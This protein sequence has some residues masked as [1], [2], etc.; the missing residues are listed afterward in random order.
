[1]TKRPG[2]VTAGVLGALL[3]AC[4][5]SGSTGLVSPEGAL[6]R[7]VRRD[8]TCVTSDQMVTYCA[9]GSPDAVSPGG[10]TA[11]GPFDD[12][13]SPAPTAT[14]HAS[15]Q[16]PT[17]GSA[18]SATF[19]ASPTPVPSGAPSASPTP[20]QSNGGP[21]SVPVTLRF[22]VHGL[23]DGAVCALAARPAA[24]SGAW[25]TGRLVAAGGAVVTIEPAIPAD[26]PPG[27]AEVALLCFDEVPDRLPPSIDTL[28]AADPDVVFAPAD[29]VTVPA[30]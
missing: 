24:T 22:T 11:D 14:P 10:A 29:P 17:P 1:M 5:G 2:F 9:T 19:M 4:G 30:R 15:G 21:C 26:V 8:G 13:G 18:P 23:P 12:G 20:C 28:A 27:R 7:E 16:T 25:S 6:L 3:A